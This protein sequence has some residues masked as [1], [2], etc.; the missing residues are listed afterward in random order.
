M[1]VYY[2][3]RTDYIINCRRNY[4]SKGGNH[5]YGHIF[6]L[7]M[8]RQESSQCN[9]SFSYITKSHIST[10]NPKWFSISTKAPKD[11]GIRHLL[12]Q[13]NSPEAC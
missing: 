4:I 9:V 7:S 2:S 13:A 5:K 8:V 10:T 1:S 3:G 11:L 6:K 12:R